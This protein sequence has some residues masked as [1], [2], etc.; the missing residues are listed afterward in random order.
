MGAMSLRWFSQPG[1][2]VCPLNSPRVPVAWLRSTGPAYTGTEVV[3]TYVILS[4]L[5]LSPSLAT[6]A[7]VAFIRGHRDTSDQTAGLRT[8]QPRLT[9]FMGCF[10]R[11]FTGCARGWYQYPRDGIKRCIVGVGVR[12]SAV[13]KI[14]TTRTH[15]RSRRAGPLTG[16][17]TSPLPSI[18]YRLGDRC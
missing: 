6:R 14:S 1:K 18:P 9:E 17:V 10:E 11:R 5:S 15:N 7:S 2:C 8:R 16:R 4:G 12:A 13:S 3:W